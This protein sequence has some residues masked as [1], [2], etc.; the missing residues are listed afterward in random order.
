MDSQQGWNNLEKKK[1][2]HA[3]EQNLILFR[4]GA[5]KPLILYSGTSKEKLEKCLKHMGKSE[6]IFWTAWLKEGANH[7]ID[8]I[9]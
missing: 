3:K 8:F 6:E 9:A 2:S 1:K 7:T 4:G 5:S